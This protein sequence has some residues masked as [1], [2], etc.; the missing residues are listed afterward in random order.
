MGR[1]SLAERSDKPSQRSEASRADDLTS[2]R[3]CLLALP[4]K[5]QARGGGGR[6]GRVGGLVV[7]LG[8]KR[9]AAVGGSAISCGLGGLAGGRVGLAVGLG[10]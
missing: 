2:W 1:R 3:G 9:G 5:L 4:P 10:C 7:G 8:E 6:L